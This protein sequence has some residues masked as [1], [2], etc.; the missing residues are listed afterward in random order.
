MANSPSPK[1]RKNRAARPGRG[2]LVLIAGLLMTSAVI[3]MGSDAGQVFAKQH[4]PKSEADM[5][6]TSP[7]SCDPPED[8]SDMLSAFQDREARLKNRESQ[9]RSRIQALA[10]ADKEINGKLAA[11]TAAE[12]ALRATLALADSAAEND[13][14]RLTTV[15]ENMKPKD[16]AALF[17]AMDP[18]FSS[19]FLARMRPE[20]AASIMSGLKPQTAY[21]ISAILAG[22]NANVPKQ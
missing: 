5:V 2:A 9:V 6:N 7:I 13:I 11:L 15:Y 17:E 10:V 22:R 12:E 14:T 1:R 21:T 18:G 20:A 8:L 19:G 3:R 16:A 4:T